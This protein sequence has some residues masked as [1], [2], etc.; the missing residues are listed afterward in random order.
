MRQTKMR[1]NRP[2]RQG[3]KLMEARN[4][5]FNITMAVILA[6]TM[7]PVMAFASDDGDG[8]AQGGGSGNAI[9]STDGSGNGT[10]GTEPSGSVPTGD[11][12]ST[13]PT[14]TGTE[15]GNGDSDSDGTATG[16]D[17]GTVPGA[18]GGQPSEGGASDGNTPADGGSSAT[19]RD[20][21]DWTGLLDD[22]KLDASLQFADPDPTLSPAYG[23]GDEGAAQSGSESADPAESGDLSA[24][25]GDQGSDASDQNVA[26]VLPDFLSATLTV[27]IELDP[28]DQDAFVRTGDWFRLT[29]PDGF[30][31]ADASAIVD[32]VVV[33][34][35]GNATETRAGKASLVDGQLK[36]EFASDAPKSALSEEALAQATQ[37]Q[38]QAA[39]VKMPA[40]ADGVLR[41]QVE[42]Q[43][44]V[45]GA[46]LSDQPSTIEWV[47][48]Q[49]SDGTVQTALL[50]LPA[51]SELEQLWQ[52]ALDSVQPAQS[53]E[54][55]EAETPEAAIASMKEVFASLRADLQSTTT[56]SLS[57][58]SGSA[59]MTIT[60]C[61]NN[62]A[63][64]PT[65]D[66][67]DDAVLPMFKI[68]ADGEWTALLTPDGRLTGTAKNALH[69]SDDDASW[70]K[71]ASITRASVG[72][73]IVSVSGLPTKLV[74]TTMTPTGEFD[75]HGDPLYD[76]TQES[77]FIEW[78][79]QDTNDLPDGY[80]Y[81]EN[82]GGPTGL[83]GAQAGATEPQRYLMKTTEVE[84]TVVGKI[85]DRTL[86]ETFQAE[87]AKDFIFSASIDNVGV[88]RSDTIANLVADGTLKLETGGDGTTCT[89]TGSLPMYDEQGRPIVYYIE[90]KGAS[91]G[92][93]Y[94]Q[95]AYNN[96][97]SPSHGSATDKA[98]A[99]GT[100]TLRHMGT[101]TFDAT[102][103]WLDNDNQED[104][105]A[106][107]FTLWRYANNGSA[108]ATT[109]SQVQL[110][111][112]Q[113]GALEYASISIE[114]QS[115]AEID[116]GDLLAGTYADAG[117]LP[118][119]DPDGYPYIYALR[120]ESAPTGYEIVYGSVDEN[121]N[122]T[123]TAP[124]YQD[125]NGDIVTLQGKTRPGTDPLI[126]NGGTV[127]NRLTGTVEVSSTKTWEIAAFQDD[128]EDVVV[129]FTAQS[130]VEGSDGDWQ[131][132]SAENAT[133]TETGWKSETLTRSFSGTFPKYNAL[134]QEL[135]YRWVE[136]GVALGDQETNFTFDDATG[137]GSFTLS[138]PSPD[139]EGSETLNFT[140]TFTPA[141]PDDKTSTD[142]IVNTFSN[143]TDQHVDKY[144]EQPDGT[145]QQ[146]KPVGE[147]YPDYL[148]MS[149]N[150]TFEVFRDG[151]LVGSFTLDGSTD[152]DGAKQLTLANGQVAEGMDGVTYE[153]TS[154]YHA[155]ILN[156]PK[157][158][159]DGSRHD[160]LVL[161]QN[162]SG[163]HTE[164]T[165]DDAARTTRVDNTYGPGEGSEIRVM[166][167]WVDG[168]DSAHRLQVV[169]QLVALEDM[170][171]E[172][173]GADGVTPLYR[174]KAG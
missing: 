105:P 91:A 170:E 68:G 95:A 119:Y 84:F 104:R 25:D 145:L 129:T 26:S 21:Q 88:G 98:Y 12:G 121:G 48:Q 160:Y 1:S 101:T 23:A 127:T 139:G 2:A 45:D 115:V 49:G 124:N 106:T 46:L 150:V 76:T 39:L 8:G 142:T 40:S 31:L 13:G 158:A 71:Q 6:F 148:D 135:E 94:Y 65:P 79:L 60:W 63:E 78:R 69:L 55:A 168:D 92:S 134:G 155:D 107:R 169:V 171:S 102:K 100:M 144:W 72:D 37:E 77:E 64:R 167:D 114:A 47:L 56:Y 173:K 27:R 86:P 103:E 162:P 136:S 157:Y 82:D 112:E 17:D 28:Q 29:L 54:S 111:N 24:A 122:V 34:D 43:V 30:A 149:G 57:G 151:V 18:E 42:L 109:A 123:D 118:K 59:S 41:A 22:L 4:K 154:S 83:E 146:I 147:S 164:R 20:A 7:V 75:D 116:L 51:R 138:L 32:V 67:Y 33:D 52:Q 130:R 137:E 125:P 36:V 153:E 165:Y 19:V 174:Y 132:V 110:T 152:R 172:T 140:S 70:V 89:I 161:E 80:V 131:D 10:A 5:F 163:W 113:T 117:S 62:S 58:Y 50:E 66:S 141:D 159:P 93:D 128:L 14:Q 11:D 81:G 9:V 35:Q 120:E 99:G 156:L 73:W 97:N 38:A 3:R 44:T 126:Y 53:V 90:Y 96:A 143:V 85:G 108:G 15:P 166:K 133:H 87:Q 16:A 74:T 61:D